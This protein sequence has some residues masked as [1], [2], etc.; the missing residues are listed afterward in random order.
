MSNDTT[1][2]AARKIITMNRYQ[3]AATHV[4]VRDGRVLGVGALDELAGWGEHTLD[5]RF[6]DKVLMPGFI[7][8]HS[9]LMQG[10]MWRY[11]YVGYFPAVDPDGVTHEGL[12]SI[13]EVV[14]RLQRIEADMPDPDTP[15]VAWGFDP[16]YFGGRRMDRHD[17]DRVSARRLV[18]VVHQSFHI[19]NVNSLVL[20]KAGITAS[21][22]IAGIV[23]DDSGEPNGEMQGVP[24]RFAAMS[25]AGVDMNREGA[26]ARALDAFGRIATRTG[27]TTATDLHNALP[28]AAVDDLCKATARDDFRFRLVPAFAGISQPAQEGA[29]YVVELKKRNNDRLRFGIVKFVIDGS[30]QGFTARLQWPGYYNG[31]PNGLWYVAPEELVDRLTPYHEAGLHLNI[32]TN[33]DEA[34]EVATD[35][36]EALQLRTPRDDHRHTLQHC[37]M[38]SEAQFARMARLGMCVNLFANHLFYYGDE[39]RAV[40]MGPDRAKRLDAVGSALRQ[41]VPFAIH[42]DAPVT[43]LGPLF[44]AWC[45]ANR[46]TA[47]G[48]VL[49][50]DEC[51]SVPEAL[52]AI[53]QG[54]AF[55]MKMDHEIGSIEVGKRADFAVL[56]EDPLTIDAAHLKDVPVWG[57][58]LGGRVFAAQDAV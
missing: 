3:P 53:T 22:N 47:S 50:P 55:T 35:A 8:G 31:A 40:T 58:V 16:I 23:R 1:I 6:A 51:I 7:E 25:V 14:E 19:V 32:H 21:T 10:S 37:Q 12:R 34:T 11:A 36:I 15:L 43:P 39:H 57:T 38:A 2:F 45:A 4:A 26:D 56:E 41:G 9:H 27:V 30:I 54:A 48:D 18:L 42:S 33:G 24:A 44:T 49:G 28:A 13:D 17:L 5:D 20:G 29:A 46:R 52:R